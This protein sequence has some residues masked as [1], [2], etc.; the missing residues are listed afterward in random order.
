M[1]ALAPHP[2]TVT[3]VSL[4]ALPAVGLPELLERAALQT[5]VDRKYL[6]GADR[7]PAVLGAVDGSLRVLEI[8][9]RRDFGYRSTYFD[10]PAL[11]GFLRAGRGRRR[12]FKVRTRTYRESG[13]TW[14]EVKTRTARG[15][16]VKDRLPYDLADAGRLTD[17]GRDF[18]A[19]IVADRAAG[20][21][22]ATALVPVLHTRYRRATV[23]VTA[24]ADRPGQGLVAAPDA[25]RVTIDS[26]LAWRRPGSEERLSLPGEVVVETKGGTR[27]SVFD[28]ALWDAGVRPSR[29][30]KYGVGLAALD[31]LPALK[32]HRIVN[33]YLSNPPERN[34]P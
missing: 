33:D 1:T 19:G 15:E 34:Q 23:L 28:H 9:G 2:D 12:R 4:D 32:W 21:V 29:V 17:A 11:D 13:E 14:L 16:T 5:R 30:S 22:D 3:E 10:T 7:L 8:D 6:L 31:D 20:E 24:R 27:P 26:G 18:V 25:S